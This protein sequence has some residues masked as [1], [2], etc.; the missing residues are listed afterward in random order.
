MSDQIYIAAESP[1]RPFDV[2]HPHHELDYWPSFINIYFK[3]GRYFFK[4][5]YRE[6]AYSRTTIKRAA[7]LWR[8]TV[9]LLILEL[10][11]N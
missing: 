1:G 11:N 5:K 8:D 7:K 6:C 9:H 2:N 4:W 10:R 3:N